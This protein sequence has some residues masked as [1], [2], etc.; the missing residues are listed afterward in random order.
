MSGDF[1]PRGCAIKMQDRSLQAGDKGLMTVSA[2]RR[3]MLAKQQV[4]LESDLALIVS[5]TSRGRFLLVGSGRHRCFDGKE[6]L[7]LDDVEHLLGISPDDRVKF[8]F[9][10]EEYVANVSTKE[11][12]D[13]FAALCGSVGRYEGTLPYRL[14]DLIREHYSIVIDRFSDLGE[15]ARYLQ[16]H[17]EQ[18]RAVAVALAE[19]HGRTPVDC[20]SPVDG[21]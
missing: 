10:L 7:S 20:Q 11:K 15:L 12:S 1:P 8:L 16:Y 5:H 18:A 9:Q 17:T 6:E 14:R 19:Y 21:S 13:E 2:E 4:K 3:Y